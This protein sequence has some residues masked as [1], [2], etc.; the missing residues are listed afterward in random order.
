MN[1]ILA[2]FDLA[3][4]SDLEAD[5]M[6]DTA[7]EIRNEIDKSVIEEIRWVLHLR[8]HPDWHLVEIPWEKTKDKYFSWSEACAWVVEQFGLPGENYET[9]AGENQMKFLF[10]HE[11]HA[12]MTTLRWI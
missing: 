11:A 12:I 3:R 10:K 8:N 1:D 9:H 7:R 2:A 6:N 4:A 5:I